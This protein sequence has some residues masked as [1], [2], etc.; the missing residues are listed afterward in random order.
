MLELHSQASAVDV[1]KQVADALPKRSK[2]WLLV[3]L[4]IFGV[5]FLL[6]IWGLLRL[7]FLYLPYFS[8]WFG[9]EVAVTY[10]LPQDL[11]KPEAITLLDWQ[12]R[13]SLLTIT[14]TEERVTGFLREYL[15]ESWQIIFQENAFELF[16]PI[17]SSINN[18]DYWGELKVNYNQN[19]L[20]INLNGSEVPQRLNN[21]LLN[22]II[23]SDE[24]RTEYFEKIE[25]L[26]KKI[27]ISFSQEQQAVLMKNFNPDD[28]FK[29]LVQY[30]IYEN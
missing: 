14:F 8:R 2:W 16:G 15:G 6:V 3:S 7:R 24:P 27:R 30:L 19:S 25:L 23:S 10:Q 22:Y 20:I 29:N 28:F 5:F 21:Y 12:W 9:G 18:S 13:D 17:Y 4:F 11:P 26:D 1:K